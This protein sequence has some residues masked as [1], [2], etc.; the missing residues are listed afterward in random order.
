MKNEQFGTF[1]LR[2]VTGLIFFLHGLD[3]FSKGIDQ[4]AGWFASIGLPEA[5]AYAVA[6]LEVIG[7]AALIL[8]LGTRV[9]SALFALLMVGAI[10]KV[11]WAAGFFGNGQMS[12]YEYDL[13]LLA[14]SVYLS[15]AGGKLYALDRLFLS[16]KNEKIVRA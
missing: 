1:I 10:V 11:K 4:I 6:G 5:L 3:K 8:G 14:I 7:G 9:F 13:A 2:V 15:L 16:G 12:G